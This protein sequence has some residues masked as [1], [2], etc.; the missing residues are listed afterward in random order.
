[1]TSI[2]IRCLSAGDEEILLQLRLEAL[3]EDPDAFGSTYEREAARTAAD[4]QRWFDPGATF[5]AEHPDDGAIGLAGGSPDHDDPSIVHLVSMWI[6]Q[7]YRG[8]GAADKLVDAVIEW[9][10]SQ[11]AA[12]VRLNV[13]G[14]NIRASKLYERHGFYPTGNTNVRERDG[15][16]EI[17]MQRD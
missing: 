2:N 8:T 13:M 7:P 6:R 11:G 5:V 12:A 4:W 16:I 14:G 10:V 17:E 1:M 9:S 15:A 3:S